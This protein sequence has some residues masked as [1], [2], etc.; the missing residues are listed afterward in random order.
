MY[1]ELEMTGLKPM[2]FLE[3]WGGRFSNKKGAVKFY[4]ELEMT[5]LKPMGLF[6]VWG[7]G[8]G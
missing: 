4:S 6:E 8:G 2:G 7:G 5:G 1:S 3:V